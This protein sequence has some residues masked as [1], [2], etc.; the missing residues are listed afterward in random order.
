M[1]FNRMARQAPETAATT[2]CSQI[3]SGTER[4]GRAME[5]ATIPRTNRGFLPCHLSP[6]YPT[7]GEAMP[8]PMESVMKT[9]PTMIV[10]M[11]KVS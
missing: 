7:T 6:M 3:W 10:D 1:G 8:Y 5:T 9:R 11:S 4:R 2:N